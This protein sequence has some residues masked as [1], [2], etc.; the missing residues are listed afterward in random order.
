MVMSDLSPG[1]TY[2][3]MCCRCGAVFF[4]LTGSGGWYGWL[5]G[6]LAGWLVGRLL[7]GPH[8]QHVPNVCDLGLVGE[9]IGVGWP[10]PQHHR[11]LEPALS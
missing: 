1:V 11:P 9:L 6:W 4:V 3:G 8:S 10:H 7:V 5:A 2:L